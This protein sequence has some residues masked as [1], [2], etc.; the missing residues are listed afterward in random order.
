[1]KR[2]EVRDSEGSA[3]AKVGLDTN[4]NQRSVIATTAR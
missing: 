1:M 2:K 4:N 3:V